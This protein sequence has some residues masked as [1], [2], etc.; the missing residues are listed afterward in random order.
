MNDTL[1]DELIAMR[2]EDDATRA[3]LATAGA[4]F[5]DY[6]PEMRAVHDKNAERLAE[7]VRDQ[8]GWPKRSEVGADG[9]EAAWLVAM[10]AIGHK[11]R[12][13][14]WAWDLTL[15]AQQGE[16]D[17]AHVATLTDRTRVLRG[18]EQ[19]YGSQ[20]DWD[21]NG[22]LSPLPITQPDTVDV[23]R[24]SVMMEPLAVWVADMRAR[25]E[26]E[27]EKAPADRAARIARRDAFLR[28]TGWKK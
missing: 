16:A 6:A 17:P 24:E 10:H 15:S 26:A 21:E 20:V 5:V 25:A 11:E 1:R 9:S 2:A 27:G 23:R 12:M 19:I 3:R 4:L 13:L 18:K 14:A 8:G 28:E 7:I 22:Q